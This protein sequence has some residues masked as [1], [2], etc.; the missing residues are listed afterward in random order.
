ME[1][2]SG[3]YDTDRDGNVLTGYTGFI[4]TDLEIQQIKGASGPFLNFTTNAAMQQIVAPQDVA[5]IQRFCE[6]KKENSNDAAV[7]GSC[8]RCEARDTTTSTI[9][10]SEKQIHLDLALKLVRHFN[11]PLF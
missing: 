8:A 10:M 3:V 11:S 2:F 1:D 6:K 9:T 5:Q 7:S 4:A